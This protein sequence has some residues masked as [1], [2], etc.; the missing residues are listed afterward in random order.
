ME[1]MLEEMR[2]LAMGAENRRTET[3]IPGSGL[4]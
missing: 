3:G 2:R 4:W 1:T